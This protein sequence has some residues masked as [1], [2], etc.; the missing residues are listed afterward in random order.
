MRSSRSS[1]SAAAR[2]GC[3]PARPSSTSRPRATTSGSSPTAA[4]T[5]SA[6]RCRT[7]SA[8]A[9]PRLRPG[10][11]QLRREPAAGGRDPPGARRRRDGRARRRQRDPG[12]PAP[13]RRPPQA[14]ADVSTGRRRRGTR[15]RARAPP[16][17]ELAESTAHG[18]RLP[19]AAATRAVVAVA[20]RAGRLRR[21]VRRAAA[22]ALPAS[23]TSAHLH[24]SASRSPLWLLIVPLLG[25]F[26]GLG[27]LYA[28]R[29]DALDDQ[30]RELVER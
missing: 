10:S 7:S 24:R 9:G 15:R 23:R 11:P 12:R 3:S 29:A 25:L 2:P 4:A 5:S 14:A 1:T 17:D 22:R 19:A 27:W 13:G 6:R 20:A 8:L 21:D 18:Q 26:V 16:R 30:F 28:R